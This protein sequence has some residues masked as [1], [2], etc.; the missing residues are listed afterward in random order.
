[1]EYGEDLQVASYGLG[2]YYAPHYDYGRVSKA[3]IAS[4]PLNRCSFFYSADCRRCLKFKLQLT[5]DFRSFNC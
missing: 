4:R 5:I 2:G 3:P 1:M